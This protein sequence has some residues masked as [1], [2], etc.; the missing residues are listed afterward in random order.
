MRFI[1]TVKKELAYDHPVKQHDGIVYEIRTS[2]LEAKWRKQ[3]FASQ[4]T[5]TD[6][7]NEA[8]EVA[9]AGVEHWQ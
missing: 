4:V 7:L 2:Q 8:S 9:N 6:L 3:G 5:L 1:V